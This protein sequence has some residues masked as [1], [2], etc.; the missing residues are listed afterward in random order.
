MLSKTIQSYGGPYV[1]AKAISNPQTQLAASKGNRVFED[2]AQLTRT[3][4]RAIVHFPPSASDPVVS[5]H[6]SVW[7]SSNS[8]K[9]TVTRNATGDYLIT[10]ASQFTDALGE[11]ETVAFLSGQSSVMTTNLNARAQI[12]T[13]ASN[14]VR[15]FTS[16]GGV[17]SDLAAAGTVVVWL[18]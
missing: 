7:G 15:V 12:A 11:V 4:L 14:V 2:A 10:Y 5:Y 17:A 13:I 1:D 8:E 3:G 16:S 9:P 6:T 18:R